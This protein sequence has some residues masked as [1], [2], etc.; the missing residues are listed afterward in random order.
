MRG[1][2]G[3][4]L[5]APALFRA[6]AADPLPPLTLFTPTCL[7]TVA[8]SADHVENGGHPIRRPGQ[9]WSD[10]CSP[11]QLQIDCNLSGE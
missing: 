10:K 5:L 2:A 3:A 1:A 7:V 8:R 4:C 9:A 11:Q 6:P